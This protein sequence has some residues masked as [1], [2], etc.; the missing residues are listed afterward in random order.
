[1]TTDNLTAELAD[2]DKFVTKMMIDAGNSPL[3][4]D[5]HR[6]LRLHYTANKLHGLLVQAEEALGAAV[7]RIETI[8]ETNPEIALGRD[9][10]MY[11]KVLTAIR[12]AGIGGV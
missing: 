12:A 4:A 7:R 9:L 8:Q 10:G 5:Q 1:M 11:K 3:S 6:Y 2:A